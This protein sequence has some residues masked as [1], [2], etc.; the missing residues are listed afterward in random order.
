MKSTLSMFLVAACALL[1]PSPAPGQDFGLA[2]GYR[3]QVV[4]GGLC[5][6]SSVSFHPDGRLTICDSGNGRVLLVDGTKVLA[7]ATGFQTEHWK[8]DAETGVK[9]FLLGPLSAAWVDGD[10]LAVTNAGL[11]DGKENVLFFSGPGAVGSAATTNSVGPTSDDPADKGEGNLCGMSLSAD[12]KHLYLAGQGAD[13]KS[14]ILKVDIASKELSPAFSADEAGIEVNSPMDTMAWDDHSILALYSGAGGKEDG[15]IVRWDTKSG[16]VLAKWTLPGLVDPMGFARI[17]DT[18]EV[19]VV[20]NNWS[21]T[22]VQPGKLARVTLTED[23]G[24]ADVTVIADKLLGPVS[25]AFGPN[26]NLYIAQLG[27]AFDKNYGQVVA[28]SGIKAKP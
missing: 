13:A 14:W 20:D 23:G 26:G 25:C 27:K 7:Y 6:P 11:K 17:G 2:D 16:K 18:N 9:R 5:N 10:T 1:H 22:D 19:A 4:V 15:L 28:V 21:L 3:S 24:A 12:G 8:V